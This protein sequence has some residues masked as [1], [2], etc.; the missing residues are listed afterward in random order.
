MDLT[1]LEDILKFSCLIN[2]SE[3]KNSYNNKIG[4]QSKQNNLCKC[5]IHVTVLQ[6]LLI[7]HINVG[8]YITLTQILDL[9]YLYT[10]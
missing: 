1:N 8:Y 5:L 7:I 3:K 4:N 10:F 9:S 2:V 6:L